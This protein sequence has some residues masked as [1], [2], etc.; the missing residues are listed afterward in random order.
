MRIAAGACTLV[1]LACPCAASFADAADIRVFSSGA[2]ADAARLLA[3]DF[4][5]QTNHRLTFTVGQLATI[6]DKLVSGEPADVVIL[7]SPVVVRLSRSKTLR[8]DSATDLARVG[9]GV[10]VR[11]GGS[12]PDISDTAAI[13]KLLL[14]A[15][16]IVYPDPST[17]GGSAGRAIAHMIDQMGIAA[18]VKGKLTLRSAIGGGVGLVAAGT[19]EV[20]LFNISEILPVRGV[21]LVGPLPAEVQNYIVFAAAIPA[22][23]ATPEPAKNFI[24]MLA[25][26]AARQAWQSAGLEPITAAP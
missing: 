2:P 3:A 15:K 4:A 6:V 16:S 24:R 7:P 19:A 14:E 20:G 13:R 25:G 8:M 18:A 11:D 23:N 26:P 10:V 5:A 17:G 21:M 1:L 9:I 12:R 22:R